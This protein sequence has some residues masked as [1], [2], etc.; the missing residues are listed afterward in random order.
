M[1]SIGGSMLRHMPG[2]ITCR[3][4]EDF[5]TDYL[6]DRLT[7]DQKRLFERHMKVCPMCRTSL[8]SYLKV[9][10]MGQAVCAEDEK[11][12][13]FTAAPQ[14]LIDAIIDVSKQSRR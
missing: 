5:L 3:Q 4:F 14:E 11:D 6:E 12:E 9:I 8:K 13:A 10:E 1:M 7:S 2:Q